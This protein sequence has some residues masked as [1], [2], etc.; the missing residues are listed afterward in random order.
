MPAQRCAS[1]YCAPYS[2]EFLGRQNQFSAVVC[3]SS[4]RP[5][6]T[7]FGPIYWNREDFHGL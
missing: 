1:A 4:G 6:T 2:A 7:I 3:R 5:S